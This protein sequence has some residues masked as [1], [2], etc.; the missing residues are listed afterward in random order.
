MAL[1]TGCG[2]PLLLN[3]CR[4]LHN[5]N[6]RYRRIFLRTAGG[7]RDVAAEHAEIARLAVARDVEAACARLCDSAAGFRTGVDLECMAWRRVAASLPD[8]VRI[9][10]DAGRPKVA[11]WRTRCTCRGRA[12]RRAISGAFPPA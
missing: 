12:A 10:M 8:A 6:D 2:M 3:A 9:V 5:L 11:S 7:D 4:V 1:I